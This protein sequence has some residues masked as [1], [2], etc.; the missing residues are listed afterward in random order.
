MLLAGLYWVIVTVVPLL[1]ARARS[2]KPGPT[3]RPILWLAAA[4]GL[5]AYAPAISLAAYVQVRLQA[6]NAPAIV[7][8]RAVHDEPAT[9]GGSFPNLVFIMAE[10][11]E[12]TFGNAKFMGE[13]LTPALTAL[14]R[15]AVRFTDIIQ[16]P[17]ASWTM[18]GIVAS[19]CSVPLPLSG[20]W[21]EEKKELGWPFNPLNT[22]TGAIE[23]PLPDQECLGDILIRHGYRNVYIGSAPLTFAGKGAFLATHGF[24]EQYGWNELRWELADPQAYGPWGLYDDDLFANAWRHLEALAAQARPFSLMLL[25][26]DTHSMTERDISPSCGRAPLI[27]SQGFTPRCTDRVI[28]D[29]IARLRAT[30]PDTVVVLMSDHLA[31]PNPIIDRVE[32]PD[33]RRLRFVVWGPELEPREITR[34]GTH[35][36]IAPTVLDILGLEAYTRHNLG[37][38]LLAFDSPWFAHDT[39]QELRVAPPLFAIHI[40]PGE[41]IIFEKGGP[42]IRVDGESL[43]ANYRGFPLR[44]AVFTM[45]FHDDGRF[46]MALPWQDF[47]D[48][49]KEEAGSLVIGVSTNASF[50]RA[51]GG[52]A[53]MGTLYFAGR[54]GGEAGLMIGAVDD[55]TEIELPETM[56]GQ[57]R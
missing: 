29:F 46:D 35:F 18:G 16:L 15:D 19:Q 44:D 17:A 26:V 3:P 25:T 47:D 45:R 4:V 22:I 27:N 11:L 37:A 41:P 30:W 38:S 51:A 28:A 32:A 8:P 36:D 53:D 39:P 7:I 31:F 20:R 57:L 43:I 52:P 48:L 54:L 9:P 55:R 6:R 13:D 10:S 2:R 33:A 34:R 14:E 5:A 23:R 12:A 40:E 24:E 21:I 50:N 49:V 1:V 56:F 42:L